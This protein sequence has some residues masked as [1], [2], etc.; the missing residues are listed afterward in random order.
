MSLA[1]W[2][3]DRLN[4]G[5]E[6]LYACRDYFLN[7]PDYQSCIWCFP[8]RVFKNMSYEPGDGP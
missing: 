7:T 1:Q 5:P 6:F 3:M 4:P 2:D 8:K